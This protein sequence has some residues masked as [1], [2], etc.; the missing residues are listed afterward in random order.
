MLTKMDWCTVA[1][2][3]LFLHADDLMSVDTTS[4]II[5]IKAG[6]DMNIKCAADLTVDVE[7]DMTEIVGTWKSSATGST[8]NHTSGGDITIVGGPNIH[9]NP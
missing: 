7:G 8:W 1:N 3:N 6:H 9:L 5:T 4:G 2:D